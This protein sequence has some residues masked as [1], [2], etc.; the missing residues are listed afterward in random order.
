MYISMSDDGN[1]KRKHG[2][3][4]RKLLYIGR[5]VSSFPNFFLKAALGQSTTKHGCDFGSRATGYVGSPRPQQGH[6]GENLY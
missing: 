2:L 5:I 4:R 3:E 6:S 1:M